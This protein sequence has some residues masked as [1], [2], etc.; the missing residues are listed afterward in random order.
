MVPINEG[1]DRRACLPTE[2]QKTWVHKIL[3]SGG[4]EVLAKEEMV[5]DRNSQTKMDSMTL[6]GQVVVRSYFLFFCIS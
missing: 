1:Q 4:N 6:K 3:E 5:D 2:A